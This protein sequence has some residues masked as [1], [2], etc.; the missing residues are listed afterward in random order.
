MKNWRFLWF[1]AVAALESGFS[2]HAGAA[3]PPKLPPGLKLVRDL[4]Y[5]GVDNPRQKLDLYLHERPAEKPRPLIVFVH[6]GGWEGGS[7]EDGRVIL[8]LLADGTYAGASVGY[9]LTGEARWPAQI[10][11]GK[12]ALRWLGE[13]A[14][15]HGC[16]PKRMALLGIS[17]G[18]HLVSLLGT[19]QGDEALAGRVGVKEDTEAVDA[20]AIAGVVNFCGVTDF[21][22]FPGQGSVID[23]EDTKGPIGRL[24][25]G[26]MS[27]HLEAAK[28]ASP[29]TYVSA[30]DPPFLHLHGTKD[31]LVPYSQVGRLDAAL[32]KVGVKST[33]LTGLDGP[34]VFVSEDLF[35]KLR[36]FLNRCLKG[37]TE[38]VPEGPVAIK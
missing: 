13:H 23:A 29:I 36:Q 18:G 22:A 20:P 28:A 25:G 9:R 30:D 24:F 26:P 6:G 32:E 3:E 17:A 8:P 11:D 2:G 16:D 10:H 1:V 34:H 37:G 7:K 35:V 15:E 12:A 14:A 21:I 38:V 4:D 33:V 19:S 31:T 27:R 5:G